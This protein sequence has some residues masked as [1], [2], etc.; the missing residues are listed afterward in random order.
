MARGATLLALACGE[1]RSERDNGRDRP[2]LAFGSPRRLHAE[3]G[4]LVPPAFHHRRL[5][6]RPGASL[7]LR[8]NACIGPKYI[9]A[10]AKLSITA[11]RLSSLP[12][13]SARPSDTPCEGSAAASP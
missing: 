13:E 4:S 12:V 3:F 10:V 1:N 8:F 7:L 11:N 2:G 6:S 5:A 9:D